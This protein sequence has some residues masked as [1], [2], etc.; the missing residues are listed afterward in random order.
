MRKEK[1][2]AWKPKWDLLLVKPLFCGTPHHDCARHQNELE[3]ILA[4]I[5]PKW[6]RSSAPREVFPRVEISQ[7]VLYNWKKLW[8]KDSCRRPWR[9]EIHGTHHRIFTDAEEEEIATEILEHS[10]MPAKMFNS[11]RFRERVLKKH[12][13]MTGSSDGFR[14]SDHDVQHFK[15]RHGFSSCRFHL[16]R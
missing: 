15:R 10:V 3:S 6:R 9:T 1:S 5:F 2:N 12:E 16:R 14:C 8:E 4:H 11:T 7:S 13:D